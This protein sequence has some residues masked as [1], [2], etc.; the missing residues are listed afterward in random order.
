MSAWLNVLYAQVFTLNI[1]LQTL[2]Q[3]FD[4]YQ[5]PEEPAKEMAF[6]FSKYA[7]VGVSDWQMQIKKE[8][9]IKNQAYCMQSLVCF[10]HTS[11][12]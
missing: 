4:R 9:T 11:F 8:V 2:C 6:K 1:Q 12:K 5:H 7:R 10:L 3:A